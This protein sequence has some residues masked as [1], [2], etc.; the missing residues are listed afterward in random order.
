VKS[1]AAIKELRNVIR[2][3]LTP[4]IK[5]AE[6]H[7]TAK[8]EQLRTKYRALKRFRLSARFLIPEVSQ[9]ALIAIINTIEQHTFKLVPAHLDELRILFDQIAGSRPGQSLFRD[10]DEPAELSM[11]DPP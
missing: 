5:L 11:G 3:V 8:V 1:A 6:E 10:P 7:L 4:I 2:E 9:S